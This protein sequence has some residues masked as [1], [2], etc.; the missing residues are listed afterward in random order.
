MYAQTVAIIVARRVA[1]HN[2]K[3]IQ[4]GVFS[5]K[6]GQCNSLPCLAKGIHG[7]PLAAALPAGIGWSAP[8]KS[9][10]SPK[11]G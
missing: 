8:L 10:T 2:S 11:V 5:A 6:A 7:S 3:V 4:K 1:K 9:L